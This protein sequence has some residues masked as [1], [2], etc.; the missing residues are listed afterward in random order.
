M[1]QSLEQQNKAKFLERKRELLSETKALL[2]A[3][4][5]TFTENEIAQIVMT[6]ETL[7]GDLDIS[8]LDFNL[9]RTKEMR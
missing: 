3:K 5:I 7:I 4:K 1:I 8:K 9:N 6:K 2:Q